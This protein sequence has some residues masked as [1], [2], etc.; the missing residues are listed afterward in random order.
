MAEEFPISEVMSNDFLNTRQ[1]MMLMGIYI[2]RP[3][4]SV[5][6]NLGSKCYKYI[7]GSRTGSIGGPLQKKLDYYG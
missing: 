3:S 4:I 5:E 1:H 2:Q 6:E 7:G